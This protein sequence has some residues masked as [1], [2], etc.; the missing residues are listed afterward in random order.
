MAISL[1]L[2][3]SFPCIL[4]FSFL[5][6]A[7]STN[8]YRFVCFVFAFS[9]LFSYVCQ[10]Q[11]NNINTTHNGRWVFVVRLSLLL[12]F[13]STF[14]I[15]FC[16]R[17]CCQLVFVFE[18]FEIN[19]SKNCCCCCLSYIAVCNA[20]F[21]VC[22]LS[23]VA[24]LLLFVYS[25]FHEIECA[26]CRIKCTMQNTTIHAYGTCKQL[27]QIVLSLAI[28]IRVLANRIN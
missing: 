21:I 17:C 18:H 13:S 20:L 24:F 23:C 12:I 9:S 4:L 26:R 10:Q 22:S 25:N 3:L 11:K 5:S 16:C 28:A 27:T 15:N 2:S 7:F 19:S 8:I 14:A 1:F 6:F